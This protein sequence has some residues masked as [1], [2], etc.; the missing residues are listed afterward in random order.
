MTAAEIAEQRKQAGDCAGALEAFDEAVDVARDPEVRRDRAICHDKLGQPFP[1]I[2]DYRAYLTLRPEAP[3]AEAVRERVAALEQQV[4]II[5]QGVPGVGPNGA[6]VTTSIGGETDLSPYTGGK[7]GQEAI[8]RAEILDEQAADSPL[9]RGSGATFGIT[10]GVRSFAN[11]TGTLSGVSELGTLKAGYSFARFNMLWAEFSVGYVSGNGPNG[12]NGIGGPGVGGGYEAR[13]AL[14]RR[15][16]DAILLQ[17]S[18]RSEWYSSSGVTVNVLEP[19]G[20][21]GYRHVFGPSFGLEVLLDGGNAYSSVGGT[22]DGTAVVSGTSS[23]ILIGGHV[24]LAL[25][26]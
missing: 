19:E 26:F 21:I 3:D 13:I 9:R 15:V 11:S 12:A 18:F 7:G 4:G 22:V 2:E 25:G 20:H 24:G 23:A 1:A 14:N 16:D 8:E 5:R 10:F 6:A 17:A